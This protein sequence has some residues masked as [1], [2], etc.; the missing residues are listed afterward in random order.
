MQNAEFMNHCLRQLEFS[1]SEGRCMSLNVNTLQTI[2]IYINDI[3][4]YL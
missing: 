4:C 1:V 2:E 3:K